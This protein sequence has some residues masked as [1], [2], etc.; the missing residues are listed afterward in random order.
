MR[1]ILKAAFW[2]GLIAF[3]M[4]FGGTPKE[5]SAHL[6]VVGAFV[7]AQEAIADLSGFCTRAPQACDTGREFA[8]FAG[9]RIGDGVA[10]A[11]SLV[12][13][14]VAPASPPP[15]A[16]PA[17]ATATAIAALPTPTDPVMTGAVDAAPPVLRGPAAYR[18]P[19]RA[20][21]TASAVPADPAPL[22]VATAHRP[23]LAVPTPAPRF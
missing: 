11:Y 9:E 16:A 10:M 8:V 12:Q 19:Q 2:L 6:S 20:V 1:F 17:P 4:P 3:F 21:E 5:T 22:P 7:G 18:P 15:A 14:R 23:A 13:D